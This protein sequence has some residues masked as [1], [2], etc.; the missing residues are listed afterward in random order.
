LS[1]F[2]A[3]HKKTILEELEQP[4]EIQGD[5]GS[6]PPS[7]Y[8]TDEDSHTNKIVAIGR[9]LRNITLSTWQPTA[10]NVLEDT[11]SVKRIR[12]KARQTITYI[13]IYDLLVVKGAITIYGAVLTA[14]NGSQQVFA[15]STHALPN[16]KCL[17]R[18]A[19]VQI[20]HVPGNGLTSLKMFSPL[21]GRFWNHRTKENI[22]QL[23]N[24]QPDRRSFSLLRAS[25]NDGLK[26]D[27]VDLNFDSTWNKPIDELVSSSN[28]PIVL[29][30][31]P[32]SS[33]KSTFC[34]ILS[35]RLL[36]GGQGNSYKAIWHLDLDSAVPEY[37]LPGQISISEITGM[38]LGPP[39][40]HLVLNGNVS[41]VALP[42]AAT[43]FRDRPEYFLTLVDHLVKHSIGS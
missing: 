3:K 43:D 37:T 33:G 26:R 27:L 39:Y 25:N 21:Y 22:T 15:P 12:L 1:A 11:K 13:G 35:N 10:T 24:G 8:T 5:V 41:R 6:D 19:E 7:D 4:I 40:T 23:A 42:V 29:V 28:P 16:I 14:D 20:K 38:N 17:S 30:C 34:R 36:S 31:G 9:Q 18:E 32:K 2:A